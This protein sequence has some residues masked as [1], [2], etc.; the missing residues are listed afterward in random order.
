MA[1]GLMESDG[2]SRAVERSQ[3]SSASR[4]GSVSPVKLWEHDANPQGINKKLSLIAAVSSKICYA[5]ASSH[6]AVCNKTELF[7]EFN[8]RQ[9]L[10]VS[11][12]KQQ[13]PPAAEV[14]LQA[15]A[16]P[17]ELTPTIFPRKV[18]AS[19]ATPRVTESRRERRRPAGRPRRYHESRA[20]RRAGS[21]G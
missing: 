7:N 8:L 13:L 2:T 15:F 10:F 19:A 4:L 11:S 20:P 14:H 5:S 18:R 21:Q 3:K 6:R 17:S 16:L 12:L 9:T 1:A